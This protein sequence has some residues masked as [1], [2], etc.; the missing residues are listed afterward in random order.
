MTVDAV[1]TST[2]NRYSH[3]NQDGCHYHVNAEL[4]GRQ[5]TSAV[6]T[7]GSW[8]NHIL[9]TQTTESLRSMGL[10]PAA[11]NASGRKTQN[12]CRLLVACLTC[13]STETLKLDALLITAATL[14]ISL[15]QLLSGPKRIWRPRAD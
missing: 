9:R 15:Q 10:D 5:G 1:R 7:R 3:C 12:S 14:L 4:A 2:N 13:S 6:F 11:L 8:V